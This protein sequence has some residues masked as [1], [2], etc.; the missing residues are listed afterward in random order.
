MAAS[1]VAYTDTTGN[2]DYLGMIA[3]QIGKRLK[4]A[5]DMAS[6]ERAYASRQ[7]EMNNTSL[8]EAGIGRGHFFKRALGSRFGGDK[9]ARTRG[10]LG[11]TGPGT[12]PSKSYKQRFRGGFDYNYSEQINQVTR[13][14]G[15]AI[16]P[17][18]SALSVGLR[19]VE[20][21]LAQVSQSVS[22]LAVS[23][24]GLAK[25]QDDMAREVMMMGAFMRAFMEY[26]KR[27][28]QRSSARNEERMLEGG[29]RRL[30][31]GRGPINITPGKGGP[32][33]GG[34]PKGGALRA[35]DT[36]QTMT[37][38]G[39]NA[40]GATAALKGG[41]TATKGAA[42]ALSKAGVSAPNKFLQATAKNSDA[43]L[44]TGA[45]ITGLP[46]NRAMLDAAADMATVP[47]IKGTQ[48]ATKLLQSDSGADALLRAIG[49][50]GPGPQR[51]IGASSFADSGTAIFTNA[52]S[53]KIAAE[54]A[55]K[56]YAGMTDPKYADL[57]PFAKTKGGPIYFE[58]DEAVDVLT[59]VGAEKQFGDLAKL[60]YDQ[61]VKGTFAH[62]MLRA[63]A[64]KKAATSG[65]KKG[66][67]KVLLKKI[68]LFAG[69]AGIAF[70][71]QRALE[72]DFLGAGLEITSG[73][74]GATGV[75]SGLSFGIDGFLLA[76]DMGMMPMAKGGFLT[77][78][79]PVVAGE[80]GAEGF[81]PLEGARGKATFKMFG[82][83]VLNAQKDNKSDVAN[84][85]A[86]GNKKYYEGM[87]G[88]KAFG[89][90]LKGFFTG[91][92]DLLPDN[93]LPDNPIS[94]LLGALGLGG[95]KGRAGSYKI[96]ASKFADGVYG[97][98]LVT[99]P[100][101]LIGAGTEYHLDSKFSKDMSMEDRVK[102]MD[103]L[104]RGYAA[105]GREIEFSNDAVRGTIYDPSASLEE[106]IALL[107]KV[108]S[109]HSH[110]LHADYDSIDYYIPNIGKGRGHESAEGAEI[111]MPTMHD[112][113]LRY[114]QG[115]GYGAFT[116]LIDKDGKI[117]FTTGH[118]DIR[119]AK[120][121]TVD[122][123]PPKTTP[124]A[125]LLSRFRSLNTAGDQ[126][127]Q[128]NQNSMFSG[129]LGG[130]MMMPTTVI[131]NNYAAAASGSGVD[132]SFGAGFDST[133]F[134]P[135]VFD[136]NIINKQ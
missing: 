94:G 10:R 27:Q 104:A 114:G 20:G 41:V 16:V 116:D 30:G 48:A 77:K 70:G 125:D 105:R 39:S 134:S 26:M 121:G 86:L 42:R 22:A 66:L 118:G 6:E 14:V 31:G 53:G 65:A 92:G 96:D 68:P 80:A 32:G 18:S 136:Y 72:G 59:S 112:A 99:G 128:L 84:L 1:T 109:A 51:S 25:Y 44:K 13:E 98:G 100:A 17:M 132:D 79:T 130:G 101:G 69:L 15:G 43:I 106:K 38:I 33:Q 129:M 49:A 23:M 103:Q 117:L 107:R 3:S 21:G 58:A 40:K 71:I 122:L 4:Q 50:S 2:K 56:L 52:K 126:A 28:Q 113:Q 123:S 73:L 102:L 37:K 75:G 62:K 115:G 64:I 8:E 45:E 131:N 91:L 95:D 83:G 90:A 7:A 120:T 89:E 63:P 12:D 97:T 108:Q 78:P 36:I 82:E 29:R 9:I 111:L 85:Y 24:S 19:G 34:G 88:W 124:Q 46:A 76:R 110:S 119:G 47:G 81:F 60:P 93:L 11:A 135:F 35:A 67:G 5:S 133:G 54:D 74:L 57:N 127:N 55:G 61:A 87:G